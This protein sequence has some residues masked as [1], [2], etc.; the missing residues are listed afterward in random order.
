VT[1]RF[2]NTS[3]VTDMLSHLQ[4]ETLKSRRQKQQLT[5]LYKIIHNLVDIP[6]AEYLQLTTSRTRAAHSL[7]Y[8]TYR[9]STD[10]HKYSF[11]PRTIPVWNRLPASAAEAPSLAS[12]KKELNTLPF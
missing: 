1:D 3:S 2:R 6:S 8:N 9:T 10:G 4:W 7:R 11:F 5:M 12:F